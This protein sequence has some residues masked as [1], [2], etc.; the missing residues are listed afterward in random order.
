MRKSKI[1]AALLLLPLC[2]AD[3]C[4]QTPAKFTS[5]I[6]S[7]G[8]T[9]NIAGNNYEWSVGEMALVSTASASNIVVTQG[10]LQPAPQPTSINDQSFLADKLKVYPVPTSDMVNLSYNY[11]SQG[12]ISYELTDMTGKNIVSRNITVEPGNHIERINL[13]RLANAAY[14]LNIKYI[15]ETGSQSFTS[16]KLEKIK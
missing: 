12:T 14:M 9:N 1:A 11:L 3:V 8:G 4:A 10:V 16:F 7:S 13:E 2:C 5:T 6:N 15:S